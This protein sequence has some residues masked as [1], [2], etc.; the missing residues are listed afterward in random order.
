MAL[1]VRIPIDREAFYCA[2]LHEE[3]HHDGER[4][5]AQEFSFLPLATV[6]TA[7][8]CKE[9]SRELSEFPRTPAAQRPKVF[10]APLVLGV[11]GYRRR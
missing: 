8:R 6:C 3:T 5:A 9:Y 10:V 4:T 2:W 7:E 1:W 11:S